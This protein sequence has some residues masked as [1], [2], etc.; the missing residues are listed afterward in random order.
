MERGSYCAKASDKPPVKVSKPKELL[1]LLVAI[2]CGP[3]SHSVNFSWIHLY[4]S[5][6][7]NEAQEEDS[8]DMKGT[9]L[10]FHI[11]LML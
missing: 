11:E 5:S 4:L 3:L 6:G 2:R 1:N 7:Y 10:S 9:F 8:V